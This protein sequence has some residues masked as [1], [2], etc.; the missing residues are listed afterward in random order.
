[1]ITIRNIL[2]AKSNAFLLLLALTISVFSQILPPRAEKREVK[3]IYFGQTIIDQYRWMENLKS[4]ETQK[5]IKAQ[6]D[7]SRAYLDKLPVR[8]EFLKRFDELSNA[9]IVVGNIQR[10]GN[11]YFYIRRAPEE[12]DFSIYVRDGLAGAERLLVNPAMFSTS[13]KRFSITSFSPSPDG[14]LLSLLISAGGNEF[15]EM[16]I[17]NVE[18]GKETGDIIKNT[19][20]F[21]ARWMPDGK[22]FCYLKF[23][24]LSST[25]PAT[26]KLQKARIFRHTLGTN[27]DA[28]QAVFGYDVNPNIKLEAAIIPSLSIPRG[29]KY[30][31]ASVDSGVSPNS[32]YYFAPLEEINQNP[33]NWRKITNLEDEVSSLQVRGDDAYLMTYK[34]TPRYKITRINLKNPDLQKAE[35]IFP[36][37][38]AVVEGMTTAKDALYVQTLDGGTGKIYRV[39]Y[40]TKKAE[41]IKLPYP[42]SA[43][44]SIN[45]F[46]LDSG[47]YFYLSSWT[48]PPAIFIYQPKTAS[49]IDTRL[50]PPSKIDMSDIEAVNAKARSHDGT[51]VPLVILHKKAIKRD[52]KNPVLMWGY[53]SYGQTMTSP[54]FDPNLLP[55]LERGGV[56]VLAGVRGGGEYGEEW[57]QA[58]KGA[59]KPN[60]WKDFI[61]C[62]EYLIKEQYTSPSHLGIYGISAGGILI[63]NAIT[64]RPELFGAAVSEVGVN[65]ALLMEITAFGIPNIS[66]LG[67]FKTEE[68]FRNLLAMDGYHK[69][70]DGVKYPAVMLLHGINDPRVEP[71]MSAKMA[72]RLQ[73]AS[74]SGKPVLL[75]IDYDAGHG[76]G[77]TKK[78]YNEQIADIYAFLFEQLG[79]TNQ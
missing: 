34:N 57:H 42:S 36:A 46:D 55:W 58:G 59:N 60:S 27:T 22:S 39:D 71:W 54:A 33:I 19:R 51:L 6:A 65:N 20:L 50:L 76:V 12:N 44:L 52:G 29:S 21:A 18:S 7:Y 37:S 25:A 3:D 73:A 48:K 69:V 47:I 53:G 38:E 63:S 75:R 79:G 77:S 43:L 72:A 15:G 62:A 31:F 8:G 1:M 24:D 14:K 5:W 30:M 17:W 4:D 35:T 9:G 64:E 28:D 49:S 74:K 45:P 56:M 13:G 26:E 40:Q 61:A 23:Q 68:G 66:E 2:I 11:L 10:R 70:K 41:A 78:Q 67:T 16:H 32:E